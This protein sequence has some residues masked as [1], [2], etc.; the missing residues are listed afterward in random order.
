MDKPGGENA[1]RK[2]HQSA[3]TRDI[4]L[5][6]RERGTHRQLT[7]FGGEDRTPVFVPG[8]TAFHY[9]SEANGTFNVHRM[10]LGDGTTRQVTAFTGAPV[11]FL[12]AARD[13]M[14]A[15]GHD[16]LIYTLT[17][18]GAPRAV[19]VVIL[20][21]AKANNER[22][23]PVTGGVS[24]LA[25][26]P[27][28]KEVAFIFRGDVF[29]AGVDGGAAKQITRTPELEQG[30]QFSPDGTTLVY[31]SERGGR[32][33]IYRAARTRAAEPYF[34]AATALTETPLV[35]NDRQNDQPQ[36]AP[37][38]TEIA[39]V[40]DRTTLRVINLAARTTRTLLTDR[41]IWSTGAGQHI[42]WSPDS[43]WI[44][45]EMSV[46]GLAPGEIGLVRADGAD[47]VRNL[48]RSGFDDGNPTWVLGGKAMIWRSTRDG[49]KALAQTGGSQADVYIQF[50]TQE[51]WD[52][53]RLNTEEFA[54]VKDLEAKAEKEKDKPKGKADSTAAPEPVT[55]DLPRA[56]QWKA[57]PTIHSSSLGDALLSKDGETLYY[58]ARFE[59]GFNLWSTALRTRETK[60]VLALNA[61]GAS[62]RWDKEQEKIVL[63]AS[64][65][66]SLI[67]P[68]SAK[69]EPV[70]IQGEMVA[71]AAAERAAMFDQVYRRVRD[72][73]YTVG[74]HGA[75]W[76]ALRAQYVRYLPHIGDHHE[77]AEML[78]ELLGELNV[79]HSGA[80]YRAS[81]PGDDATAS[82][83]I[84]PDPSFAGE[85]VP[86]VEVLRGGPMD[87]TGMNVT[88]GAVI[89]AVDGVALT[90]AVDLAA[91]LNRKADR[92][93]LVRLREGRST[94][95]VVVK[96]ISLG[97]ESRLL[98]ERWV[99][100]N[101]EEVDRRSNGRLGYIHVPGMNDGAYRSAFEEVMGKYPDR[102]GLVVDTR[103]NGGG[104]LVADLEMFLSGRRFF[105]YTT[106]SR[107]TGFEPNFRWTRPSIV[108]ANEGNYSDGHCFAWA[109]KEMGLGQLVGMPVPGTCPFAGGAGLLDGLS[110]GV[111]GMGVKDAATGR[112]LE[113][114]QT[115]PDLRVRNDAAIVAAGRDQ[116]L[117]AAVDALLARLPTARP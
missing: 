37:D 62:M 13:G 9:L 12:T 61:S 53:F 36:Y 18:G 8:D 102:A 99:R 44:L 3:V 47:S 68:A 6:D 28:G 27:S 79:S 25:V 91:L 57:R 103:W 46:P 115:E 110:F 22:V 19:P 89:T 63:L 83:G 34:F 88:A 82:L 11:R 4:W 64:G 74:W 51:A 58:L 106:D 14:L 26:A 39:Y 109:F 105:D 87:R 75:D 78:S 24:Q 2:H 98:Y 116:Q 92:N 65:A 104:D 55:L 17:P 81:S 20:A 30:V 97:A 33:A 52:R 85:G 21:D 84:I 93:V 31:A 45:F 72:T 96:P 111:P 23:I 7:T 117:E 5:F 41:H 35:Q 15:F 60:M 10:S 114:W 40:E 67:D 86:I 49:L 38:G 29:A 76:E 80:R 42:R 56:E 101:A 50:F 107:S 112:Y 54:L 16:G 73:Y 69:R 59:R 71:D 94:R 48:T 95:E 90:P 70:A 100:R 113:N 77:F 108:L 43:K 1:W 66:V 32:W